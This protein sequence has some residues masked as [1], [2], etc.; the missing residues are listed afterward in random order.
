[1]TDNHKDKDEESLE[2][3]K[4]FEYL[5]VFP[6][7]S[8][9]DFEDYVITDKNFTKSILTGVFLYT[10][11]DIEIASYIRNNYNELDYLTGEWF[12]LYVLEKPYPS[13]KSL[14]KHWKNILTA[15]LYDFS[16]IFRWMIGTR[17]FNKNESYKIADK[18][19]VKSEYFPCLVLLPPLKQLSSEDKL[20]IPIQEASKEYFR[21]LFSILKE[22]VDPS[23]NINKY[24]SVKIRFETMIQ[25]LEETSQK[26][27]KTTTIEY[28][29]K[30]INIFVNNQT[31]RLNMS[32][33]TT[34]FN[35]PVGGVQQG[36]NNTQNISQ[37]NYLSGEEKQTLAE[38][39]AE[40]QQLLDQLSKTYSPP[41]TSNNLKIAT[42]TID[43]IEKT[44]PLKS[45]VVNALKAGGIEALKELLDNPA[46]NILMASIEGWNSAE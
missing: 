13:L 24:E 9:K 40:I 3:I 41:S 45:K 7:A 42:E 44:P 46:V 34:N 33:N 2:E 18:L 8:S 36:D 1:M 6:V 26:I 10:E 30:G 43:I 21:K 25:Y 37:T 32:N 38:A 17:P 4:T 22:I 15:K 5:I 11:Q 31:T 20:I 27:H 29:F 12:N 35:A 16:S 39:A 14:R 23:E 28:E 19:G